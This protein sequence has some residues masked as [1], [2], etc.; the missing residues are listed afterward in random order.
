MLVKIYYD[1]HWR[2]LKKKSTVHEYVVPSLKGDDLL[3]GLEML[4]N[5]YKMRCW[6]FGIAIS[7]TQSWVTSSRFHSIVLNSPYSA[8]LQ[9]NLL[10][11][12]LYASRQTYLGFLDGGESALRG[13]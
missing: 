1:W 7:Q 4:F 12:V 13:S 10:V 2:Q 6:E 8:T 11:L 9:E 3:S 5:L